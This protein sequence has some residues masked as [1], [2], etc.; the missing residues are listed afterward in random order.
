M[1]AAIRDLLFG[2]E[3]FVVVCPL[4]IAFLLRRHLSPALKILSIHLLVVVCI[5]LVSTWLF[6]QKKNNLFLLHIFTI[7][8]FVM[9][10]LFYSASLKEYI[11]KRVFYTFI[12]LFTIFSLFNS[13][14]LQPFTKNNT[15]ARSI[16]GLF[17]IAYTIIY[18]YK[19]LDETN[20]V[21]EKRTTFLWISS[22]FLLYFSYSVLLFTLSNFIRGN[23][24]RE[25]RL[26]LWAIHA[27]F[28]ILLYIQISIGLWKYRTRQT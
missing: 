23:D 14:F 15:Y 12:V 26:T 3:P 4:V 8:E 25:L 6:Y 2:I 20:A 27:L 13:F 10:S 18:F 24:L 1:T 22:G 19:S 17:I 11:S 5:E 28:S 9:V 16:E 7:E 21:R